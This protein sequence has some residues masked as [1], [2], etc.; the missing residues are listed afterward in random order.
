MYIVGTT[1]ESIINL[2]T[3]YLLP[4][5]RNTGST[6]VLQLTPRVHGPSCL[7]QRMIKVSICASSCHG[8]WVL[9]PVVLN[10]FKVGVEQ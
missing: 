10:M 5:Q 2:D 3:E 9:M 8:Q 1:V 6:L 7:Y 4:K